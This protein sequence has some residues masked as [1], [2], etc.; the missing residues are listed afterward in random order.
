MA[1]D[2]GLG[3]CVCSQLHWGGV[4]QARPPAGLVPVLSGYTVR[5]RFV[6]GNHS[7]EGM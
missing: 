7:L 5:V 3:R 6:T 2:N 4:W 1:C